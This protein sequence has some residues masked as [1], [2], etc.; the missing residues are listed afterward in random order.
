MFRSIPGFGIRPRARLAGSR[1]SHAFQASFEAVEDRSL[2]STMSSVAFGSHVFLYAIGSDGNLRGSMDGGSFVWDGGQAKQVSAGLD[3]AGYPEYYTINPA[4]QVT[5]VD[6]DAGGVG[7]WPS[8]SGTLAGFATAISATTNDTLFYVGPSNA[9]FEV[10]GAER[11]AAGESAYYLGGDATQISAGL[12]A[13]GRA[14][15]FGIGGD[16]SVYVD[17]NRQGWVDLDLSASAISAAATGNTVYAI[18]SQNAVYVDHGTAGFSSLGG[19]A[20]AIS[21][22]TDWNGN[23]DVYAIGGSNAVYVNDGGGWGE[24]GGYATELS[25]SFTTILFFRGQDPGSISFVTGRIRMPKS[26]GDVGGANTNTVNGGIWGGYLA[27]SNLSSPQLDSVTNVSAS[28]VVPTGTTYGSV[29]VGIDG[30]SNSPGA[31]GDTVEQ[32]GTGKN[33]FG[34]GPVDSAWFEMVPLGAQRITTMTISPGDVITAGVQYFTSGWLAGY[35]YLSIVDESRPNDSF[36]T[37]EP[38]SVSGVLPQR[39]SAEWIV[40]DGTPS[41]VYFAD[42]TATIDGTAGPI[43]SP[44]WQSEALKNSTGPTDTTSILMNQGDAFAARRSRRPEWSG[45]TSRPPFRLLPFSTARTSRDRPRRTSPGPALPPSTF[46]TR[47]TAAP[48]RPGARRSRPTAGTPTGWD[49]SPEPSG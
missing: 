16:G 25:A 5:Y 22:G 31:Y 20:L 7:F 14:E 29:W 43:N 42:A 47:P 34:I 28:W 12:D 10:V 13:Y 49:G 1:R 4:N 6:E 36:A 37:L 11:G 48:D 35:F 23:P 21:A 3:A 26:L 27:E 15:V 40:E 24:L 17:D 45:R 32:I 2:M 33:L 46:K 39:N 44:Y 30:K 8:A 41:P 9:V 18:G 38:A 19:A